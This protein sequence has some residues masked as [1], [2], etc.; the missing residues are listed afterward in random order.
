MDYRFRRRR[1]IC[2][3]CYRFVTHLNV[4]ERCAD[5]DVAAKSY[6][7]CRSHLALEATKQ[8]VALLFLATATFY[9]FLSIEERG[10]RFHMSWARVTGHAIDE[11]HLMRRPAVE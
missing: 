8:A 5:N 9:C 7:L 3:K 10:T 1:C 6:V 4:L 11:G 2:S